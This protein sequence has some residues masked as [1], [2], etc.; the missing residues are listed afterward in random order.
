MGNY[1]IKSSFVSR[2]NL[3]YFTVQTDESGKWCNIND[4][5][6]THSQAMSIIEQIIAGERTY[7]RLPVNYK[8]VKLS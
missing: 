1:R 3:A 8:L 2:N 6:Y 7:I 5:C 4:T